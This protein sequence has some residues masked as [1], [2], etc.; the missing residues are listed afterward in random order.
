MSQIQTQVSS[1]SST[2]LA[3]FIEHTVLQHQ[4]LESKKS[5]KKSRAVF[6][7]RLMNR[8]MK[9]VPTIIKSPDK[10]TAIVVL[11]PAQ[12][13][14]QSQAQAFLDSKMYESYAKMLSYG[15][16]PNAEQKKHFDEYVQKILSSKSSDNQK[17]LDTFI[18][19]GYR[20][21]NSMIYD[22]LLEA[23]YDSNLEVVRKATVNIED[24]PKPEAYGYVRNYTH[25]LSEFRRVFA[26][27]NFSHNFL[28]H[29]IEKMQCY[30]YSHELDYQQESL[31]RLYWMNLNLFFYSIPLSDMMSFIKFNHTIAKKLNSGCTINFNGKWTE[32]EMPKLIEIYYKNDIAHQ[33]QK[34]RQTYHGSLE[35][36]ALKQAHE[37][38]EHPA[39]RILPEAV[40][41]K[42]NA[43]EEVY[44][45]LKNSSAK[46]PD[47]QADFDM[48]N[49]FEKR[50]PEVLEKYL[51]VPEDYRNTMKHEQTGKTAYE[52]M[53]ESLGNYQQKLVAML[54]NRVQN[55]LSDMN[56]TK[57][58]S[59]KIKE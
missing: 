47:P 32:R 7:Q 23:H 12:Q 1:A 15:Y 8:W 48:Q 42:I 38:I 30:K 34:T 29:I 57:I 22:Y 19:L 4:K 16:K 52:L 10:K 43:I 44:W 37:S 50:I 33:L 3:S 25:F 14:Q 31:L 9:N 46:S 28:K 58:Y 53:D 17:L 6:F 2:S 27:K 41:Q 39:T 20:L 49:I 5:L 55:Q 36:F 24:D 56:A 51:R 13:E 35:N 45:S 54:A 21:S 40:K 11:T 59:D 18:S 26:E